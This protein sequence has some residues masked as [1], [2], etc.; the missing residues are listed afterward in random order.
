MEEDV[1]LGVNIIG[2]CCGHTNTKINVHVLLNL[3][4]CSLGDLDSH[5]S[6]FLSLSLNGDTV[7]HFQ[8]QLLDSLLFLDTKDYSVNEDA[9]NMDFIWV[10][11]SSL[12]NH[13]SFGNDDLSS[14][15]NIW[16]E[17]PGGSVESQVTFL[18]SL[19]A[20]N[21]GIVSLNGF[22]QK[23]FFA[24][25]FSMFF[26]RA[27]FQHF[28]TTWGILN[29]NLSSLKDSVSSSGR[30]EGRDTLAST[31]DFL[32]QVT[33]GSQVEFN[34]TIEVLLR[35]DRIV[36][37]VGAVNLGDLILLQQQGQSVFS[38]TNFVGND[39]DVLGSQLVG[40]LDEVLRD[41]AETEP[42]SED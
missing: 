7:T 18:I 12:N 3:V 4:G 19:V 33:L 14:H 29:R 38:C 35:Q 41:T 8:G 28:A 31:S 37:Y 1:E 42:T 24:I 39:C 30:V 22:F 16:V 17:V 5:V 36:S 23:I 2:S 9:W 13:I 6:F 32:C 21:E 15:G 34:L 10:E 25:E 40:G 20:L 26:L 27:V 11:G